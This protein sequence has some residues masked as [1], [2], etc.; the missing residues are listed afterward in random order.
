MT[1]DWTVLED[2]VRAVATF[3]WGKPARAEVIEGVRFDAVVRLDD[4]RIV[5]V[6]ATVEHNLA[7]IRTD[8]AK[9]AALR[10]A[11]FSKNTFALCY[12]V[13]HVEPTE[14]MVATGLASHVNVVS[15]RTFEQQFFD[16]RSY[17]YIR[18]D[19]PFG[20]AVHPDTGAIARNKYVPVRFH[21]RRATKDMSLADLAGC[22]RAGETVLLSGEYGTG[23]SRCVQELFPMLAGQGHA[24]PAPVPYPAPIAIDLRQQWGMRT[25]PEIIRRHFSD[26]GMPSAADGVIRALG[27]GAFCLLLDG[28]DEL[29]AQVWS[30]NPKKIRQIRRESCE[31]V[32]DLLRLAKG[33]VLI[34][35][36]DHYFD[37]DAEAFDAL[38]LDERSTRLLVTHEEFSLP[39]MKEFL[40]SISA[41]VEVPLWLPRRP[42]VA[43]VL[44]ELPKEVVED[45]LAA[46]LGEA[47]FWEHFVT[48]VCRRESL[49]RAG[50]EPGVV[51]AILRRLAVLTRS[52]GG[53]TGPVGLD[54][55]SQAF[56][57]EVGAAPIDESALILHRLPGLGRV[58]ADSNDRRFA[59]AYILDGLRGDHLVGCGSS[60]AEADQVAALLWC[61]PLREFGQRLAGE[62]LRDGVGVKAA[63]SLAALFA[64]R[65]NGTAAADV[66]NALLATAD[67][68]EV[69]DFG[70]LE[71]SDASASTLD[72]SRGTPSGLV[73]RR[74]VAD[75]LVM[76]EVPLAGVE[77]A[78]AL[79]RRVEGITSQAGLPGWA[80]DISTD[81]FDSVRTNASVRAAGLSPAHHILVT[82]VRK[83]F[84]QK[85]AA[86]KETALLRGLGQV[87]VAGVTPKV[88]RLLETGGLIERVAGKEGPCYRPIRPHTRRMA[89]MLAE[90]KLSGDPVWQKVGAL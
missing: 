48:A 72:L 75:R 83:T 15:T 80:T 77:I 40:N 55:I 6:E 2:R 49:I 63:M 27:S 47:S 16:A 66:V 50:L 36:R 59:D 60:R 14:T 5:L 21:D 4:G 69:L 57:A 8:I 67:D 30:E 78:V 46:D 65:G 88:L 26:L 42:L 58:Q 18:T 64:K 52:R 28:F 90:L 20:S 34:S 76:P 22:L 9:F 7:K 24:G 23:K 35:G 39:E 12:I 82:I 85:G 71:V 44:A 89:T 13:K 1:I 38:G 84:F 68:D 32:R 53:D 56:E 45:L 17:Q 87:D 70:A 43:Q 62:R 41:D 19:K 61:N 73:F 33:P 51:R 31:G 11:L 86:R 3:I 25:G 81:G 10:L 54:E 37:S 79:I 29:G 74:L